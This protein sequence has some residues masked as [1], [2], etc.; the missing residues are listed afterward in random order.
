MTFT[1]DVL[2]KEDWAVL[3]KSA[4]EYSFNEAREPDMDR[5]D[6]AIVVKADQELAC[7][8]TIIELDKESAYMQHG[9]S[10]PAVEKNVGTVRGYVMMIN[11]LKEH[12][13][14]VSTKIWNKNK[15]MLKLS[16]AA[17]FEVI[18]VGVHKD[19]CIFLQMDLD[20]RV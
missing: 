11:Y 13:K 9:G 18:G 6:Y 19:G 1:L 15:A 8:A 14:N 3:S 4:H 7:Y 12:Y 10:F 2:P 5:I 17:G 20:M 16:M